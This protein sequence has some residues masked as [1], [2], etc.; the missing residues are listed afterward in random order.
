MNRTQA[1]RKLVYFPFLSSALLLA[2]WALAASPVREPEI[3]TEPATLFA[4]GLDHEAVEVRS[5]DIALRL[6]EDVQIAVG[7]YPVPPSIK[8]DL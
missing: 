6:G 4:A 3:L 1:V 2:G 8:K 5:G 7:T